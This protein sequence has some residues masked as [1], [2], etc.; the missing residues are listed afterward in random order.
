MGAFVWDQNFLTGFAQVDEQH[1]I[2]VDLFN[3]LNDTLMSVDANR[4]AVLEETFEKVIDYT[5]YH[6]SDEE[7][8]M[9]A[10]GLAPRHIN[11][12]RSLHEQFVEQ[13]K[14]MRNQRAVLVDHPETVVGFLTGWLGLHILGIDQSMARQI[15]AIR[16]GMSPEA[17]L[18]KEAHEHDQ[19]TQALLKVIGNLYHVLSIQ[20]TALSHANASLE[21]RV[22]QRT[23]ELAE[24]NQHLREANIRLEAFSRTDGLLNIANRGYFNDRFKDLCASAFRR[25]SP[26]G[27]LLIDVDFFKR[28]NDTYGHQAGDACLQ[29]VARAV[30]EATRR[31]TDLV[32]RYGGEE[33]AVLLPDTD[34]EGTCLIAA[35]VVEAV[36]VLALEHAAS[37]VAAHVSVS[38]GAVSRIPEAPDAAGGLLADADAAL[39]RAKAGGR[40]RWVLA[41]DSA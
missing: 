4:D 24:A 32:A 13:V 34:V 30:T 19:A 27:L 39:Y 36:S 10:E 37:D 25:R 6:F 8:M 33:L 17:A 28:Y 1:H 38:V 12:H 14:G 29:A 11:M 9:V 2:L 15:T 16:G 18:E 20:N 22:A 3:K 7:G 41:D 40:C 26:L 23:A 21:E 35:Q 31:T 5:R